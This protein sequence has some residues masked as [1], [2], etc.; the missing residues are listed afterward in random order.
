MR[1]S[2]GVSRPGSDDAVNAGHWGDG[3]VSTLMLVSSLPGTFN[4]SKGS[5]RGGAWV[6]R[7]LEKAAC[8]QEAVLRSSC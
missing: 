3:G 5:E 7:S 4:G 1:A 2:R 8:A 6:P